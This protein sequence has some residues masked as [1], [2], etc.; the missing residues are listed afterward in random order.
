MW[1]SRKNYFNLT[2]PKDKFYIFNTTI[3]HFHS[4]K[5]N[6]INLNSRKKMS[7]MSKPP[8]LS[9]QRNNSGQFSSPAVTLHKNF[10]SSF[11]STSPQ[12]P[13]SSLNKATNS[14]R[15]SFCGKNEK[16]NVRAKTEQYDYTIKKKLDQQEIKNNIIVAARFRP[17]S[18]VELVN[19][20][21]RN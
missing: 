9:E 20:L 7:C 18:T 8:K 11:L 15:K 12:L 1:S 19:P 5:E 2:K 10:T 3:N 21:C 14:D 6:P 16:Q 13:R 4:P 17:F